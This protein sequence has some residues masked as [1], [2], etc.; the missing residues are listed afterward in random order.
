MRD[1]EEI[2]LNFEEAEAIRLVDLEEK[3]QGEA[4]KMMKVSQPTL[5]RILKDARRKISDAIINGKAI[6]IEG[7]DYKFR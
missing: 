3:G 4:G 1:L 6:R 5:S 7:G 2:G